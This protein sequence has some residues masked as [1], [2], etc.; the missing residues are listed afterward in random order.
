MK[1]VILLFLCFLSGTIAFAQSHRIYV[2]ASA[3][4][5]NSGQSWQDAYTDLQSAIQSSVAGD[6]IWIAAGIYRPTM[7]GD[8][9][10]S[11]E[12]KSGVQVFGGFSG[13]EIYLTQRNWTTHPTTLSG[14]IG[15][16]GDSTDNSYNVVYLFEPDSN[17]V[18][19]G[20]IIR[21]GVAN[22]L[23]QA[24]TTYSRYICG[25]GLYIMADGGYAYPNIRNC[26]FEHNTA[27]YYGAGAII[28][29]NNSGSTAPKWIN[30]IFNLNRAYRN[31][32]GLAKFGA[33]Q[34]ERGIDLDACMFTS[35]Y[36]TTRGGGFFYSDSDGNDAFDIQNCIFE[37]NFAGTAG[38]A[39]FFFLGRIGK[40]NLKLKKSIFNNNRSVKGVA[41]AMFTNGGT[42][43]GNIEMD[44]CSLKYNKSIANNGS[45]TYSDLFATST[46]EIRIAANDY[47]QNQV[48]ERLL[49][50]NVIEGMAS[51]ENTVFNN[52]L[53]EAILSLSGFTKCH[54]NRSIFNHNN[55]IILNS[56]VLFC[57]L[58]GNK[59]V[60]FSNCV[61]Y[62]N[63]N[64]SGLIYFDFGSKDT[65]LFKNC[66]FHDSHALFFMGNVPSF[67]YIYNTYIYNISY[68]QNFSNPS[69]TLHLSNSQLFG[70]D[71][72]TQPPNVICEGG[73]IT[74]GDPMFVDTLHGDFHLQ[75]CSPL[76]NAGNNTFLDPTNS[77][78]LS[79]APRIQGGTVDIGAYETPP[80][81]LA[82]S[83][84]INPACHN[85]P[86]GSAAL[87]FQNG[88]P[89]FQVAWTSGANSGQ[90]LT[91]LAAGDYILTIT[92]ARG[93]QNTASF[94]I[95]EANTLS[96]TAQS[97][98]VAC[99]DTLGGSATA[100]VSGG[101][102]PYKFQWP[103]STD[104]IYTNLDPGNYPL[105]VT[106]ALGCTTTGAV[107]V[108]KTGNLS[109]NVDATPISC[110]GSANGSFAI[111]PLNGK[112]PYQWNWENG[113]ASPAYGPLSPGTY[114]GTLTDAFGCSI[115]WILPLDQPDSLH[116]N[117]V[118]T[119]ATDSMPGNGSIDIQSVSGGTQPYTALWNNGMTGLNLQNLRPGSYS[120]TVTDHNGCTKNETF[121][122]SFTVGTH[123]LP[124][125]PTISVFPNPADQAVHVRSAG[126]AGAYWVALYNALGQKVAQ[127]ETADL[128]L[129]I[130]VGGLLPGLYH[131]VVRKDNNWRF[132]SKFMVQR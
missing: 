121:V 108:D 15:I 39:S 127:M 40:T 88:C 37:K 42:V 51:I 104:S 83:T 65:A 115:I 85:I 120:V 75:P 19:D 30:C 10:V 76:I 2:Q 54:V 12:P 47:E 101:P 17:T 96:L 106:D 99:G 27:S 21:D 20:L 6:T 126:P 117:A 112:A 79:G 114:N 116:L 70:F 61:M 32:G 124:G 63:F 130:N 1:K 53:S 7:L 64:N 122:V 129:D 119:P 4:G 84:V 9:S 107:S 67:S 86:S 132:V 89:P 123:E 41:I 95:P 18:L 26:L 25:G 74:T 11:F 94:T 105:T 109:I 28:N 128:N 81:S 14:D 5:A 87:Q 56:P 90:N 13:T 98:P 118:L 38:G 92:D 46:S 16:Q 8:R 55:N 3:S 68:D 49:Y 22:N 113:P 59:K 110:F 45:V 60:A 102:G 125:M 69:C 82:A 73:I 57:N 24:S 131:L 34:V 62:D 78:D 23:G 31:G 50:L 93:S 71:C 43:D 72:S 35:N 103:G 29:G 80:P 77:T 44:S 52:N 91:A 58:A 36:A 111:T 33:S 97:N 48:S 100:L 66:T